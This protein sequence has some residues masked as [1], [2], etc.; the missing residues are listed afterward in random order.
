[1]FV[2]LAFLPV[3]RVVDGY[4]LVV[5][6]TPDLPACFQFNEYFRET[7]I[8]GN[9]PLTI[10]NH[11]RIDTP[12]TN[13]NCEGY[14]SRLA[15]RAVKSHLNIYE[16]ILLFKSEN[17]NKE[18]YLLQ[19]EGGQKPRNSRRTEEDKHKLFQ[20]GL[21]YVTCTRDTASYLSAC[22]GVLSGTF[23]V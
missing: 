20:L 18:A 1:M 23:R 14:N 15:K 22:S 5:T 13:N 10:W 9:F 12:R 8:N 16:L 2:G 11:F 7:W 6:H 19:M 3:P 21:E 17:A 4:N